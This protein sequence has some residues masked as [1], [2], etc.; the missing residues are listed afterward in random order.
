M[1][2]LWEN[3][4]KGFPVFFFLKAFNTNFGFIYLYYTTIYAKS[5]GF[6]LKNIIFFAK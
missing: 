1:L 3:L 5:K 4:F 6:F 2:L